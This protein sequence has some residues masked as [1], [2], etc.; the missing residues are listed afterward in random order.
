[1]E[2]EKNK[3]ILSKQQEKHSAILEELQSEIDKF[4]LEHN[5][6]I[7]VSAQLNQPKQTLD[8]DK[9]KSEKVQKYFDSF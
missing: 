2:I 6:I 4:K 8:M 5:G 3:E 1:M 9:L 7:E